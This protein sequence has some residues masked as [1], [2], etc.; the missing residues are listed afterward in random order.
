VSLCPISIAMFS[1][2][3]QMTCAVIESILLRVLL[4]GPVALLIASLDQELREIIR[5]PEWSARA[6]HIGGSTVV[7]SF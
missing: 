5:L 1:S 3:P 6:I 4:V 7:V 2:A